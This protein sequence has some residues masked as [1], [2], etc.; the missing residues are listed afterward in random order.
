MHED[1]SAARNVD[2]VR[3]TDLSC[4]RPPLIDLVAVVSLLVHGFTDFNFHI[5]ANILI[6][7][8]ILSLTLAV[9]RHN[10]AKER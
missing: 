4:R 5:P 9:V 2:P 1:S 8:V 7:S 6:F 10:P 3:S